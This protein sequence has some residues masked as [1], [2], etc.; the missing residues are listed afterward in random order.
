[1]RIT[2]SGYRFSVR[3]SHFTQRTDR[4]WKDDWKYNNVISLPYH[5]LIITPEGRRNRGQWMEWVNRFHSPSGPVPPSL[6]R[7]GHSITPRDSE[8]MSEP[9]GAGEG[10]TT[11][12]GDNWRKRIIT[13]LSFRAA[14]PVRPE[15]DTTGYPTYEW[16]LWYE[17]SKKD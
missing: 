13:L 11:G 7:S 1:M 9:C 2:F 12:S 8:E 10:V 16:I 6:Q 4:S 5:P 17:N 14:G 3:T 15:G